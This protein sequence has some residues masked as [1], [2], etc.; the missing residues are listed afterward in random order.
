MK[1]AV[2]LFLISNRSIFN[3]QNENIFSGIYYKLICRFIRKIYFY[4]HLNR[5]KIYIIYVYIYSFN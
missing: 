1:F 3:Y 2:E 5:L 4:L